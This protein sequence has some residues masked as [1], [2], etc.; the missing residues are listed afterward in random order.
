VEDRRSKERVETLDIFTDGSLKK[1]NNYT[2]GG[3]AFIANRDGQVIYGAANSEEGTTNQRME[4]TAI[5][6]ALEYAQTVRRPNEKVVIYSDSA[7][8]INCY[9]QRWFDNWLINGWINSGKKP[10]A[11]SDLWSKIIPYFDNFWYDFKK[12]EG[13][14]GNYWNE[15]CDKMAQDVSDSLKKKR[16][17][18]ILQNV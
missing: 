3:W 16:V 18:E 6:K 7:Y 13:H 8:A 4:L 15:E 5:L 17:K 9:H 14:A 11:N 12:V 2:F 1:Y 10:V